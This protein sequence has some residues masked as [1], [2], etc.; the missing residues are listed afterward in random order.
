MKT[1]DRREFIGP[2]AIFSF[3]GAPDIRKPGVLAL[4]PM[5]SN[6]RRRAIGIALARPTMPLVD[7][8]SAG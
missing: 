7:D 6:V 4:S 2:I 8:H 5:D 3:Y 1:A